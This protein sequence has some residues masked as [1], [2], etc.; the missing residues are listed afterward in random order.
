MI[1][2]LTVLLAPLPQ[3]GAMASSDTLVQKPEPAPAV[4]PMDK[5][6]EAVAAY[7]DGEEGKS[8][9]RNT[10]GEEVEKE[11]EKRSVLSQS[12]FSS[13]VGGDE[14]HMDNHQAYAVY[15]NICSTN[16]GDVHY[17]CDIC[18]GG[19]F[20]L[21]ESCSRAGRHCLKPDHWMIK[22][23]IING[24]VKSSTTQVCRETPICSKP[25]QAAPVAAEEAAHVDESNE[26]YR[27]CNCCCEGMCSLRFMV[28]LMYTLTRNRCHR[29]QFCRMHCLRGL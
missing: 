5:L 19:D 13:A 10:I 11:I 21:C 23:T 2:V 28:L 15:C 12:I 3:H 27:T 9:L 7:L 14:K 26:T 24:E 6:T 4:V 16:I 8:K 1:I 18:D 29:G 20:D 25:A 22:R 17:H